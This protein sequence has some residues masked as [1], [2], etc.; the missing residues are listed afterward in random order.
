MLFVAVV[1]CH[2]SPIPPE[3]PPGCTPAEVTWPAPVTTLTETRVP[4]PPMAVPLARNPATPEGY[5][6]AL[7]LGLGT[8]DVG[9]GEARLLRDDLAPGASSSSSSRSLWFFLDQSDAQLA[10]TESPTRLMAGD[11]VGSTQ[12]AARPQELWAIHALDA[13]LRGANGF[14]GLD[15]AVATGDNADSNQ[16]NELRW[17]AS[18][19]DG[20]ETVP[21]AGLPGDQQDDACLDPIDPFSP[22]GV[23]V[24]WYFVAGNHDVLVQGNFIND[25]FEDNVLGQLADG[26]TRD[27][28]LP[29]GPIAFVTDPD[30]GRRLLERGDIAAV[31]LES[32][33]GS[34]PAGHGFTDANVRDGTLGWSAVPVPGVPIRLISVDANPVSIGSAEVSAE[35]RDT[36]LIPELTAARAAGQ[37]VVLTSHYGLGG[38]ALEGGG[39]VGDLLLAWPEVVLVVAGHTHTNRIQPFGP[40]GD[41]AAFWQIETSSST[42]WPGLSRLIELVDNGDGTLSVLTTMFDYPIPAGSLARQGY[43]RMLIDWQ[44]GWESEPGAGEPADRNTELVQ[45]LP[46]GWVGGTGTIGR[47]SDDLP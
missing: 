18:V 43:E 31:L 35:E 17:F 1:A 15:F 38:V 44:A 16:E 9:A 32:T 3:P 45:V 20:V 13:T 28:A 46:A 22:V 29:G 36:W 23:P 42:D 41:P 8:W 19:F 2:E 47:R 4:D 33:E 24:P 25:V 21:D 30:P 12:A 40:P 11:A 7:D 14:A 39:T 27:L 6:D 5:A 10:D 37:L 34:G 26:G